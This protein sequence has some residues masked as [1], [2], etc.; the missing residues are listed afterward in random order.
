MNAIERCKEK[1]VA[2]AEATKT[3]SE[4]SK[5]MLDFIDAEIAALQ[6]LISTSGKSVAS[7]LKEYRKRLEKARKIF[8]VEEVEA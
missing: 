4:R 1:L 2:L 7:I 3:V 6:I 8:A 5:I